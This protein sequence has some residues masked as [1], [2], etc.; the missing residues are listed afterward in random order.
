MAAQSRKYRFR[1]TFPKE[2]W[3]MEFQFADSFD[4]AKITT[5]SLPWK[6]PTRHLLLTLVAMKTRQGHIFIL[7]PCMSLHVYIHTCIH[8]ENVSRCNI[9]GTYRRLSVSQF[10]MLQ[11]ALRS[12]IWLVFFFSLMFDL[13]FPEMSYCPSCIYVGN[14]WSSYFPRKTFS[15]RIKLSR[16]W[17]HLQG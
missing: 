13:S 12:R 17:G 14:P 15:S 10:Q 7:W 5:I 6:Y 8:S 9:H 4:R 2:Q 11:M 1:A 3:E 16:C